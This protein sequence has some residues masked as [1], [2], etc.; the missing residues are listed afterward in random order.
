MTDEL[1]P[2]SAAPQVPNVIGQQDGPARLYNAWTAGQISLGSLRNTLADA[3]TRDDEPITHLDHDLWLEMFRAAGWL[4]VPTNLDNLVY[5]LT[6]YRGSTEERARRMSWTTN[7]AV[8]AEHVKRHKQHGNARVYEAVVGADAVLAY[9]NTGHECE[10]IVDPD[11]L[12]PIE[13][14]A[15]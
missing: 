12:G 6:I 11:K 1:P 8:A 14:T 3:W 13:R 5:P 7:R 4:K 10:V 15:P 2:L 9:L